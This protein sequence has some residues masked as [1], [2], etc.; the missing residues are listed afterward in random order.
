MLKYIGVV[1][2]L[3][4]LGGC[5]SSSKS[6]SAK[7]AASIQ[8]Q[9]LPAWVKQPEAKGVLR[10]VG[11]APRNFQGMHMQRATAL[12]DARD[13]L[14]HEIGVVISTAY[15]SELRAKGETLTPQMR[16][17]ITE[18]SQLLL[19]QSRQVDGDIDKRG[20]LYLL[21]EVPDPTDSGRTAKEELPLPETTPFDSN[22]LKKSRCYPQYALRDIH[23]KYGLH[24]GKPV[25]FFRPDFAGHTGA[26]GIAE[27]EEGGD[28]ET[29]KRVAASLARADL[30]KR[31]R[32]QMD[33][34][35]QLLRIFKHDII[36]TTLEKELRSSSVSKITRTQLEDVWFDPKSCEFYAWIVEK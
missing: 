31:L 11:S 17:R 7:S 20:R 34:R 21:V 2:S 9:V 35:H 30:S 5:A 22:M 28:I 10:A 8:K 18:A 27:K 12:A 23:T 14:A 1:L 15:E 4:L 13:K 19:Q 26:V 32:L 25:W 33:S 36:G 3:F 24:H 16:R 6:A 29:Q